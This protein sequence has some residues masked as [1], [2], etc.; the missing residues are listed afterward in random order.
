MSHSDNAKFN[1]ELIAQATYFEQEKSEL[2][3][4]LYPDAAKVE[5]L[6]KLINRY[7]DH[8]QL[9][10]DGSLQGE[11][12]FLA[13]IGS[14]VTV[15]DDIEGFEETYKIVLPQHIDADLGHI[16]FMSPLGS[17]L[18]L[19]RVGDRI[20]VDSPSGSYGMLLSDVSFG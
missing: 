7:M 18:L 6:Q 4:K 1:E 2:L 13:W 17:K 10:L 15:V 20:E 8:I 3:R 12:D 16:S 14:V 9:V 19:A 5:E 11:T